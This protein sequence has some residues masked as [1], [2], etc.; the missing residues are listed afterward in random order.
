MMRLSHLLTV[1][2]V[3]IGISL[4]GCGTQPAPTPATPTAGGDSHAGHTHDGHSHDGWWCAEHGIPEAECAQCNAKLAAEFQKNGDWCEKHNRPDSQCFIC[5]PEHATKFAL[6][7]EAK[8]GH[9]P[10][11]VEAGTP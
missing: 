5:H 10:P 3:A 1:A 11:K 8:Y 4:A 9:Q 6:K 7:Y 2:A